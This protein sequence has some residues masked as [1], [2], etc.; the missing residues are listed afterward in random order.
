MQPANR[1]RETHLA[2]AAMAIAWHR[3]VL[4]MA[5]FANRERAARE[6]HAIHQW[7]PLISARRKSSQ[8]GPDGE[9]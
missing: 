4:E 2:P 8:H 6:S 3:L 1:T 5:T 7:R 9:Q